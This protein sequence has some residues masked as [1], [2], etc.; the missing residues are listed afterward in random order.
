MAVSSTANARAIF[1]PSQG[2]IKMFKAASQ[3][4]SL[5]IGA[6]SQL[7]PD[8]HLLYIM[9]ETLRHEE[10]ISTPRIVFNGIKLEILQKEVFYYANGQH[11]SS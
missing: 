1:S 3:I 10:D 7:R 11:A 4:Q 5:W 9:V 6:F 8:I 2:V